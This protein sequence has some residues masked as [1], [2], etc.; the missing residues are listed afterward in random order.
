[1]SPRGCWNLRGKA[2]TRS[3]SYLPECRSPYSS[4]VSG[5]GGRK[6]PRPGESRVSDGCWS[7]EGF[8]GFL[9]YS[10]CIVSPLS[11][12][13]DRAPLLT[14]SYRFS[15]V[16][17]NSRRSCHNF[18]RALRGKL[19]LLSLSQ[20]T[21]SPLRTVCLPRIPTRRHSDCSSNLLLLYFSIIPPDSRVLCRFQRHHDTCRLRLRLP[22]AYL[23]AAPLRC[24]SCHARRHRVSWRLHGDPLDR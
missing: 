18:P 17:S 16:P 10:G 15:P 8:S 7:S 19:W 12:A 1:M 24:R 21:F 3:R 11:P 6:F 20:R 2:C 4:A 23:R 14:A 9:E 5:C 22:R 13:M